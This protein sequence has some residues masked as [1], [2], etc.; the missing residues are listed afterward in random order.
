M[1]TDAQAEEA[2]IRLLR[3]VHRGKAPRTKAT[4]L[5]AQTFLRVG[6]KTPDNLA[7]VRHVEI[8]TVRGRIRVGPK[9]TTGLKL[10]RRALLLSDIINVAEDSNIPPVVAA[11]FP[12]LEL[13][14][15]HACL[16]FVTMI[17]VALEHRSWSQ[18]QPKR[19]RNNMRRAPP[20]PAAR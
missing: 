19:R 8:G 3:E 14:E 11:A 16:R 20:P 4:K 12:K 17:L 15:W 2:F 1:M 5:L 7:A 10:R 6:S 13:N 9:E 18:P